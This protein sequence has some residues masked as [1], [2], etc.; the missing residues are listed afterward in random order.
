LETRLTWAC[1]RWV[2]SVTSRR[3]MTRPLLAPSSR[4]T[5]ETAADMMAPFSRRSSLVTHDW[6][7]GRSRSVRNAGS[8]SGPRRSARRSARLRPNKRSAAGLASTRCPSWS[9]T[10]MGSAVLARIARRR[11]RSLWASAKRRLFSYTTA[12]CA[13]RVCSN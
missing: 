6:L 5:G 2:S 10:R 11:P 4:A 1:S 8:C 13:A 12:A 7:R 3:T 9:T